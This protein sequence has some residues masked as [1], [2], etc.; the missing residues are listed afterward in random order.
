MSAMAAQTISAGVEP[1]FP[2]ILPGPPHDPTWFLLN[3]RTG[4]RAVRSDGLAVFDSLALADAP[5]SGRTTVEPSGSLGGIRLPSNVVATPDCALLLLDQK[6]LLLKRLD[7]CCCRFDTV[8]CLGGKGNGARQFAA[9]TA[10][11]I[12]AG[13]LFVCDPANH[14]LSV[15]ALG[16]FVLRDT[17]RPPKA[18]TVSHPWEPSSITFDGRGVAWVADAANNA[19]HLFAP[20]GRWIRKMDF[21]GAP[22]LIAI[23]CSN[24]IYIQLK[25]EETLRIF[26]VDGLPLGQAQ[27][28]AQISAQFPPP[29][30]PADASGNLDISC[31]CGQPPG[32]SFVDL[33]GAP[34]IAA[35]PPPAALFATDGAYLAM[36][37]S[38]LYRCQWHRVVV[39]G[40]VPRG[41][42]LVVSTYTTE[43]GIPADQI[44]DLPDSVWQTNQSVRTD[45]AW[46]CLIRSGGGRYLWLKLQFTGNG[47]VTPRIFEMRV[48]FPRI[49]L[50]R[51][52]PAVFAQDPSASDFTDRFLAVFDTIFR[53]IE[54]EIDGQSKYF[55]P[56]SAP[57]NAPPGKIDF[58]SW[59][60]AWVGLRLDRGIPVARRRALVESA[61]KVTPIR[62]TRAGLKKQLLVLL[63]ME[64]KTA[65]CCCGGPVCTCT[66]EPLNCRPAPPPVCAWTAPPLIL[67]HYQ[68]R[69]WL[70]VGSGRLGDE[71]VL[72][73]ER[74]V[75]RAHLGHDARIGSSRFITTPDP[76]RDPFHVY[77]HR[78]TV[79]VPSRFGDDPGLKRALMN[80]LESESPAHT[81][82]FL[83]FVGPRF[84]IGF[85]STI[86]LNSV[87]GRYPRGIRLGETPL[88]P[89]SV[90]D[91]PPNR[92]GGPTVQIGSAARIG[93]T[94]K[95][96]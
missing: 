64:P 31:L 59:L 13:N 56:A 68:L 55:D 2:A 46:D 78:F 43:A 77:A 30:V 21:P 74:I 72:W 67:E 84:R 18:V 66:P 63:G 80:I 5:G 79:F 11:A 7:P 8:P 49:S 6:N 20:T 40:E 53:S 65:G 19:V 50:R 22:I 1:F 36:L 76:Y 62:G 25:G 33:T 34:V 41:S 45:N 29:L 39:R 92:R 47:A 83:E 71:S 86:G 44:P 94:T 38:R 58:L 81:E 91:A 35:A 9:P 73:S 69:R 17:W 87:V 16:G 26:G 89:A 54:S 75:G 4:W 95:L 23:D 14:R 57:A 28:P 96:S 61:G 10:I 27:I 85:Q 32:T 42:Q 82:H 51:Y 24:R 37:D 70:F 48:E 3:A 12:C 93:S 88:G 60:G 90:L 52:L 15:F